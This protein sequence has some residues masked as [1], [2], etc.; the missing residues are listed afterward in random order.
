MGTFELSVYPF[1]RLPEML[2]AV[3]ICIL[4]Q[5]IVTFPLIWQ[6]YLV[7]PPLCDP[8]GAV[9]HSTV[10]PT[11][12]EEHATHVGQSKSS[13]PPAQD[14][15]AGSV[16][17]WLVDPKMWEC[18]FGAARLSPRGESLCQDDSNPEGNRG[19]ERARQSSVPII[20]AFG[21]NNAQSQTIN[22]LI[23]LNYTMLALLSSIQ[24]G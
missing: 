18:R 17:I 3:V 9:S 11:S 4:G 7:F 6:Q 21:F 5:L 1:L 23:C 20:W 24:I 22:S 8:G 13:L 2:P 15:Q 16:K 14:C 12:P 19:K 10:S